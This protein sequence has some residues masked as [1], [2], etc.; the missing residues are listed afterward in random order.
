V[1]DPYKYLVEQTR[2]N[3][4]C[5][6]LFSRVDSRCVDG[7]QWEKQVKTSKKPVYSSE[8]LRICIKSSIEILGRHVANIETTEI[9]VFTVAEL[10]S[11][12]NASAKL[13][14]GTTE[15]TIIT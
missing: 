14:Y 12:G 3:I 11:L 5:G 6:A 15:H 8:K 7:D 4:I 2:S 13:P 9:P 10:F 1:I